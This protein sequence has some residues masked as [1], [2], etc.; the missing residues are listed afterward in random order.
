MF[1]SH[2]ADE[3]EKTENEEL[4]LSKLFKMSFY[5]YRNKLYFETNLLS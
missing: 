3:E 4:R 5:I 1:F 2:R